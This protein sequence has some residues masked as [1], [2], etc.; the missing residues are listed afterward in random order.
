[1]FALC[2][3]VCVCVCVFVLSRPNLGFCVTVNKCSSMNTT[4]RQQYSQCCTY[5]FLH[6][7]TG[8]AKSDN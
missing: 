1:M 6:P 2:V 8:T 5:N 3:R 7:T 4:V